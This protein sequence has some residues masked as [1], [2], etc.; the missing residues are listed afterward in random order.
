MPWQPASHHP[1]GQARAQ[2]DTAHKMHSWRGAPTARACR[3]EP[4]NITICY[5][6]CAHEFAVAQRAV[7]QTCGRGR[8]CRF[9]RWLTQGRQSL[10]WQG[11][12][13][14]RRRLPNPTAAGGHNAS[15]CG[16]RLTNARPACLARSAP[17]DKIG[18]RS[19]ADDVERSA[20]VRFRDLGV[21]QSVLS[22]SAS[23]RK[24]TRVPASPLYGPDFPSTKASIYMR[25]AE[26]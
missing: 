22:H 9:S 16:S 5:F 24:P 7:R 26:C 1:L 15:T 10:I 17:G 2:P 11:A 21:C 3:G 20:R 23:A 25:R 13:P 19:H 8:G 6:W 14:R 4:P 18:L 12:S